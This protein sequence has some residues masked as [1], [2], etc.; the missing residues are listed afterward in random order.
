MQ[1]RTSV[2]QSLVNMVIL[3]H[4]LMNLCERLLAA[5]DV[6]SERFHV[7]RELI[8]ALLHGL[9]FGA[10]F[11]GVVVDGRLGFLDAGRE[12]PMLS[13]GTRG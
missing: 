13:A 1:R 10:V 7:L 8:A 4:A 9:A 5:P 3:L 12:R 11:D 2:R 6:F